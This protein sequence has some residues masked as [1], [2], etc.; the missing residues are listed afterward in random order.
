MQVRCF[1]CE[2]SFPFS[3]GAYRGRG[4]G[5]WQI[6][7]CDL[8]YNSNWDGIVPQTYPKLVAHLAAIGVTPQ[9]NAKRY[10]VWPE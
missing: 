4:I 10:L 5:A 8:C 1:L 9:L 6:Q 2:N 7:V 3:H